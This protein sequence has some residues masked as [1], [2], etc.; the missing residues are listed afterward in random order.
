LIVCLAACVGCSGVQRRLTIRSNPP[1][2]RVYVDGYEIGT[3]PASTDFTYYGTREIRLVK[4]GYETL[5]IKQPMPAPWFQIPPLD[6]ISDNL[7][8]MEIRDERVVSFAMS[9]QVVVPRDSL[10]SRAEQLR[11]DAVSQSSFIQAPPVVGGAAVAPPPGIETLPIPGLFPGPPAPGGGP[12]FSPTPTP[13]PFQTLPS[14]GIPAPRGEYSP[15]PG[16][17]PQTIAPG[18]AP[19]LYTP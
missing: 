11:H 12:K 14:E 1:G 4:D 15:P 18:G 19:P 5:T 16:G 7:L 17:L 10:M 6:L 9:P 2:A 13:S 8:P 3:T